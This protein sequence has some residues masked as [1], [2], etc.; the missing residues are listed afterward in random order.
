MGD[1]VVDAGRGLWTGDIVRVCYT[2]TEPGIWDMT[3]NQGTEPVQVLMSSKFTTDGGI[4]FESS[5]GPHIMTLLCASPSYPTC[6]Q[7]GPAE[8]QHQW[9]NPLSRGAAAISSWMVASAG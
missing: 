5:A 2:G 7:A 8:A 3:S 1:V 9:R 4:S 6:G